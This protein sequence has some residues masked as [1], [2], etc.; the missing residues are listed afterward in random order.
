MT[1]TSPRAICSAEFTDRGYRVPAG[2]SSSGVALLRTI[3]HK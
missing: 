1:M 3:T 2:L